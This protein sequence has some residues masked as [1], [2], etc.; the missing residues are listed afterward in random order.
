MHTHKT[1]TCYNCLTYRQV[2]RKRQSYT[3]GCFIKLKDKKGV[4]LFCMN[5]AT[6]RVSVKN[7]S[8]NVVECKS[9]T[10]ADLQWIRLISLKVLEHP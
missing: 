8:L 10:L 2:E 5:T 1:M 9:I 4:T 3:K 6:K 7:K